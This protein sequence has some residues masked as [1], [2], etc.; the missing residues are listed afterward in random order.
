MCNFTIVINFI[1]QNILFLIS[2]IFLYMFYL[3]FICS[4]VVSNVFEKL[5][6]FILTYCI[7]ITH[8][9]NDDFSE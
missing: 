8:L 9:I 3:L 5:L 7:N 6:N 4:G 1:V 2:A